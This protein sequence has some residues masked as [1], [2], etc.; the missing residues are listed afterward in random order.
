MTSPSSPTHWVVGSGGLLGSAVARQA[1]H[2]DLPLHTTTVPW[3][4]PGTALDT[5]EEEARLL[6]DASAHVRLLWCA[7]AGVVGTSPEELAGELELLTAF[8]GRLAAML[9]RRPESSLSFFLASSAG[10]VYAGS[11][12]G[13]FTEDTRPR[14]LAPYGETKLAAE[15]VL[16]RFA[17][18]TG[19]RL[20]IGRIANLYG[21]GQDLSKAQGLIS[22]LC[23]SQ[24]QRHPLM[25]YV[26]LDTARDYVYVDDAAQM[27]LAA[28]PLVEAGDEVVVK[29]I[30]SGRATAL[31]AI[32]GELRRL[33]NRRPPI[34]LG[35]SPQARLQASQLR[36]RSVVLPE[37]DRLARTPLPAGMH[38][39]YQHIAAELRRPA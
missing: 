16:V 39:T 21:P 30:A 13:P 10:G 33:T 2:A 19:A 4:D 6:L 34:V 7:G 12:G 27:V 15:Q 9:A 25:V 28:M 26:P 31:A 3:G 14:P 37:V 22:Q 11:A 18:E 20:L 29:I 17:E 36:F 1:A 8:V 38:A 24:L 35:A 23:R 5:L 32:I